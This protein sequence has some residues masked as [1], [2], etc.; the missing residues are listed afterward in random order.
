MQSEQRRRLAPRLRRRSFDRYARRAHRRRSFEAALRAVRRHVFRRER[1]AVRRRA[2]ARSRALSG[3]QSRP[4]RQRPDGQ[5]RAVP[6]RRLEARRQHRA[7]RRIPRSSKGT[8]ALTRDRDT[9]RSERGH[10]DQPPANARDRLLLHSRRLQTYP[11]LR[12][13]ARYAKS[14]GTTSTATKGMM[15]NLA[16]PDRRRSARAPRHRRRDR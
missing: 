7:R 12:I 3:H 8:P 1:S 5:R 11:A 14:C 6:L 4:V 16:H 9:F 2:G 15:F 10:R 13:G